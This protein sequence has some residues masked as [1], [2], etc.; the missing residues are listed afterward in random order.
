M[1]FEDYA[2]YYDLLYKDKDY[3]KESDYI[4]ELII[5]NNN[6]NN[7]LRILDIGCGTGIHAN[8]LAE[9]GHNIVGID[10]SKEMIDIAN[11]KKRVNTDFF[12]IDASSYKFQ[13]KFDIILSLFHVISYQSTNAQLFQFLENASLHLNNNGLFIF[14]F[15]YG[16]AV[17]S[18][19]PS[20]RVKRLQNST[21]TLHRTAESE[22]NIRRNTVDVNY[23]L[24]VRNNLESTFTEVNE[25][26]RMRYFFE[27][28]LEE[29]L[30]KYGFK[31]IKFE[32]WLTSSKPNSETWGVCCI[33]KLTK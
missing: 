33:A 27:V 5:N 8:I 22:I 24:L 14:D 16:P 25:T 23:N 10:L 15:W 9:K 20:I 26:H 1:I 19:K 28:E 29:Y 13:Q 30:S 11:R 17:L 32:E 31:I 7:N 6:N 4:Y 18:I 12:H 3:K 21:I 2:S